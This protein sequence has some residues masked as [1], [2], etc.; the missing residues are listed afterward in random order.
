V[1]LLLLVGLGISEA[2]G[3]TQFAS[4]VIRLNTNEGTLVIETD[5]PGVH[6]RITSD[7]EEVTISGGGVVELKLSPGEYKIAAER[8]GFSSKQELVT[9]TRNRRT[10]VRMNLE[11]YDEN[12]GLEIAPQ[13]T[14]S[15]A[16]VKSALSFD[17]VDDYVEI[18]SLKHAVNSP[19]TVE[20]I[21]RIVDLKQS[22]LVD[23]GSR[24]TSEFVLRTDAQQWRFER[25]SGSKWISTRGAQSFKPGPF[26][27]IAGV[28]DGSRLWLFI[29]GVLQPGS[30]DTNK[31]RARTSLDRLLIGGLGQGKGKQSAPPTECFGGTIKALRI[32]NTAR[33][34]SRFAA[35][36]NFRSDEKTLALY[37]FK[38]GNGTILYDTSGNG[39][40]GKINGATWV[41]EVGVPLS[42]SQGNYALSFDGH[43][44]HHVATPVELDVTKPFTVEAYI[45]A[46]K[47]LKRS[48]MPLCNSEGAGFGL[49]LRENGKWRMDLSDVRSSKRY[50]M[51]EADDD[52]LLNRRTQISCV[53]DGNEIRLYI[54]GK[55]QI[56][57]QKV[58]DPR[59]SPLKFLI[60]ANPNTDGTNME[61]FAGTIDEV[62]I[63]SVARYS[64]DFT[65]AVRFAPDEQ[66]VALYHFDEGVGDVVKDASGNGHHGTIVGA[67]WV[68][69]D[70][71]M[72][73]HTTPIPGRDGWTELFNG[74][75]L[76]GWKIHPNRPANWAVQN[77]LLV[78]NSQ[79]GYLFSERGNYADFQLYAEVRVSER[80]NGGLYFRSESGFTFDLAN[81]GG[82]GSAPVGY[83][84][85]I[86]T[87]KST[88]ATSPTGTVYRLCA[89]LYTSDRRSPASSDEVTADEWFTLEVVAVGNH[90]TTKVNGKTVVNFMDESSLARNGHFILHSKTPPNTVAF[91]KILVKELSPQ[92]ES[93]QRPRPND[94]QSQPLTEVRRFKGH[95]DNIDVV[96]FSPDGKFIISGGGEKLLYQWDYVSGT[97]V[98]KISVG[99][100]PR[101]LAVLPDGRHVI[102]SHFRGDITMWSLA[103]G[104]AVKEFVGHTKS[105]QSIRVS[106]DGKRLL[107]A[108]YDGLVR[109]W[110]VETGQPIHSFSENYCAAA[111]MSDDGR[112]VAHGATDSGFRIWETEAGQTLHQIKRETEAMTALAFSPSGEYV[113]SGDGDGVIQVWVVKTGKE[114]YRFDGHRAKV[115]SLVFTHDGRHFISGGLDRTMRVFDMSRGMEVG[116]VESKTLCVSHL[117]ISPD[118]R[119]IVSGGGMHP[120]EIDGVWQANKDGDYAIHVWRLSD[121][122]VP[123]V[124]SNAPPLASAP[125]DA[126]AAK[127]HQ[128]AWADY[129]GVPVEKDI[130]L[131]KDH[132][133]KDLKLTMVLVPPGEFLMGT[134]GREISNRIDEAK[135]KNPDAKTL[136]LRMEG[137]Q[138]LVKI[139]KP[140]WLSKHEFKTGQFRRF[141]EST[142]YKTDA[143]TDGIGGARPVDGKVVRDPDVYWDMLKGTRGDHGPV[144]N[145]SHNDAMACCAWLTKQYGDMAFSLPTEAQWEFACRAGTTTTWYGCK[146]AEEL[147]QFAWSDSN[148]KWINVGGLLKPNAFGLYDMH[149]NVWELCLDWMS[150][151]YQQSPTI[152]PVRLEEVENLHRVNRGGSFLNSANSLRSAKRGAAL[153][154]NTFFDRGFRVAAAIVS[155]KTPSDPKV[156]EPKLSKR[157]FQSGEWIDVIPLID[158]DEDKTE[159][160][161]LTGNNKWSVTES[162]LVNAF[163]EAASK[164][165][166]P[167][168]SD[169][170]SYECEIEFTRNKGD[171]GFNLNLPNATTAVPLVFDVE[172]GGGLLLFRSGEKFVKR[173]YSITDG[174]RTKVR[175]EVKRSTD[176]DSVKV[177]FQDEFAGEWT[178]D[179]DAIPGTRDRTVQNRRLSLWNDGKNEFVFHRIRVKLRD[180]GT[181]TSL[182]PVPVVDDAPVDLIP[183]TDDTHERVRKQN[184][185]LSFDA[186]IFQH[187]LTGVSHKP[188]PREYDLDLLVER[189]DKKSGVNLG[190]LFGGQQVT[191]MIDGWGGTM[192]GLEL[193]DGYQGANENNPTTFKGLLFPKGERVPVT[194]AVR[195]DSIRLQVGDR[196]IFSWTGR[197]DQLS[198]PRVWKKWGIDKDS[199]FIGG[200]ADFDIHKFTLTPFVRSVSKAAAPPPAVAPFEEPDEAT[201]PEKPIDATPVAAPE[202]DDDE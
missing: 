36:K 10:V 56:E 50:A 155:S 65:P 87:A 180:G 61:R 84:A 85:E 15:S 115:S 123:T 75:D 153:P 32:S 187:I 197:P 119:T 114:L 102:T 146:T 136:L 182:R 145:V 81:V 192:S 73:N 144:V 152:D 89:D 29:N 129:L 34:T 137:P 104:R 6:V 11:P 157:T 105:V 38:T 173:G 16:D 117:A 190:I 33:Y 193:I 43:L 57:R 22:T 127:A 176:G 201:S 8:V 200:Q 69:A 5:D 195:R 124:E 4:T 169:W 19:M 70:G 72:I 25:S 96:A 58:L 165:T 171:R 181:V 121:E 27:H 108:G 186:T 149:G 31:S 54:D 3:L 59:N 94:A 74:R 46:S 143:E 163:D 111:T 151:I 18:P 60:G 110:D 130:I 188:I 67:K 39:N 168:D 90:I 66:T 9:I 178:G 14:I 17:G 2:T 189:R 62:R 161:G 202:P 92:P 77:R 51:I 98:R 134:N 128:Q 196:E 63:S 139:T 48:Q 191:V 76:L 26:V 185:V 1:V 30:N 179:L 20:A 159:V 126:D 131:G 42:A 172:G 160:V 24:E 64:D 82:K 135:A 99:D 141:V 156:A 109:L 142:G 199:L 140:F 107:S 52:A 91:R 83:E 194:V 55:A 95:T 101:G 103:N 174:E 44:D 79:D 158:P 150:P 175:V 86:A 78:L 93:I 88:G 21:C 138:H 13:T 177:Y 23:L 183:L 166:L 198:V 154:D 71:S 45:T 125:F 120:K 122:V 106:L 167:L 80:G 37:E 164:L 112:F 100:Y 170:K 12:H 28:W 113:V 68:N 40:H 53:F 116:K 35:P 133:G 118:G 162:E 7:G 47:V 147:D 184:G 132:N 41:R 49:G 148:S 97:I